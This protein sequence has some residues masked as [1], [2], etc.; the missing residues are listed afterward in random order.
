METPPFGNRNLD[1]MRPIDNVRPLGRRDRT[2]GDYPIH[3]SA[4]LVDEVRE[5]FLALRRLYDL[6]R[7][8][9]KRLT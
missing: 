2:T 3:V 7:A 5:A 4:P 9:T 1:L 6:E 8:L